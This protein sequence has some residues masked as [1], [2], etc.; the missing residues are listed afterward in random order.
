MRHLVHL[1]DKLS[2]DCF[3]INT[4][5]AYFAIALGSSPSTKKFCNVIGFVISVYDL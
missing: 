2:F 1:F 4:K 3:R 5:D